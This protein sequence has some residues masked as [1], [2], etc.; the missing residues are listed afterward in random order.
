MTDF[1]VLDYL[2]PIP[3]PPRPLKPIEARIQLLKSRGMSSEQI[4]A[5]FKIEK[6]DKAKRKAERVT[7]RKAVRRA[8]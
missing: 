5:L 2:A 7:R 1:D 8:R 6:A 4:N 3:E